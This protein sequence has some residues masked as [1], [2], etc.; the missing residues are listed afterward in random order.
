MGI[1]GNW[2]Q[3]YDQ[4]ADVHIHS[5]IIVLYVVNMGQLTCMCCIVL[6]FTV[7]VV[8]MMPAV[9]SLWDGEVK[10][11]YFFLS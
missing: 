3:A 7:Y 2:S 6:Y 5:A 9:I 8:F 10:L 11:I 4:V 1:K